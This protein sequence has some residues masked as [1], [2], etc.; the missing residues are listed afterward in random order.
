MGFARGTLARP[1]AVRALD[2]KLWVM[3][4]RSSQRV[5]LGLLDAWARLCL[6]FKV[7]LVFF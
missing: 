6:G 5:A 2:G 3:A 4:S 1:L 7:L